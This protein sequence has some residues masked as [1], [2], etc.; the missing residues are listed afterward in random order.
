MSCYIILAAFKNKISTYGSSGSYVGHI[1]IVL[2]VRGHMGQQVQPTFNP[3]V[4]TIEL[5][6]W[7]KE[8][9]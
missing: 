3:G 9:L 6:E 2:W 1:R 7:Y 4:H 5:C 8:I